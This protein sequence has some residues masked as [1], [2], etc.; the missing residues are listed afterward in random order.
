MPGYNSNINQTGDLTDIAGSLTIRSTGNAGK[1]FRLAGS[2]DYDLTIGGDLIIEGGILE[3]SSGNND[4]QQ[5]ITVNGSF[6]QT[7]GTF[8]RSNSNITPL[9]ISFNGANSYFTKSAG[10]LSSGNINWK[11]N[12]GKKLTLNN[13]LP[14]GLLRSLTVAGTLDMGN[15]AI[16][17]SGSF[18]VN[19]GGALINAN[20]GGLPGTLGLLTGLLTFNSGVSYT[21][22][23]ATT[24]PFPT[25]LV[26]VAAAN[27]TVGANVTFNKNVTVSGTFTLN[28]GKATIAAGNT[29]TVTSGNAI[30]GSGFDATKHIVTQVNTVTGAKGFFRIQNFTGSRTIP[31]GNGTYYLP[32]TLITTGTNDFSICVFN[33]VTANGEPNGTAYTTTQKK[34]WVDA[35]WQ[36]NR[37]A[38]TTAVTMQMAWPAALEGSGFQNIYNGEIGIKHYGT[39]WETAIGSGNQALN[40]ALRSSILSFSPFAVA[41]GPIPL[42][43]KFGDI[44]AVYK[45]N[46][47]QIDWSSLTE[48]NLEHYEIEKST[49]AHNFISIGQ[50]TGSI[51]S[52][53]RH[54][55]TWRDP[56]G[57][58]GIFFYRIKAV[59][60]DGKYSYSTIVKV[61]VSQ[62][63]PSVIAIY[64]NP[65]IGSKVTI[66]TGYLKA[67]SYRI[68]IYD[69]AGR[70]VQQQTMQHTGGAITQQVSLTPSLLPGIYTLLVNDNGDLKMI[71]PFMVQ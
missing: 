6:I 48:M 19:T 1:E 51:N 9:V 22:L 20:T 66:Q 27:V 10:T 8:A 45:N 17:G 37:N 53:S 46:N 61:N 23:S 47:V 71:K 18:I 62:L 3:A 50:V 33:G 29:I 39:G 63:S 55:Y 30:A 64:P 12:S 43:L 5:Y 7:G 69:Q 21:F 59:D 26:T 2:Q 16:S 42:P 67:G 54:D 24:T 57:N 65:V 70:I 11:V 38:G 13:D 15:K 41:K 32:V 36:V 49:D 34:D 4:A 44:K 35:V 58:D 14:V 25:L 52:D 31:V 40:T 60:V 56:I 68:T 28:N